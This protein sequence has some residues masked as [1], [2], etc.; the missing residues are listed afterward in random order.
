M[1]LFGKNV[2]GVHEGFEMFFKS[3]MATYHDVKVNFTNTLPVW[4]KGTYVSTRFLGGLSLHL[5]HLIAERMSAPYWQF[6]TL[7]IGIFL[8]NL[9][10]GQLETSLMTS[11]CHF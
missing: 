5:N 11:Y 7:P 8:S 9:V 4:L 2:A 10:S 6:W 1:L 3:Q